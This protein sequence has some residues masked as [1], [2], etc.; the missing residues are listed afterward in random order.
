MIGRQLDNVV[1]LFSSF[2]ISEIIPRFCDIDNVPFSNPALNES[3][4]VAPTR[5]KRLHRT[6]S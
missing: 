1:K 4:S 6:L 5:S 3:K 2:G